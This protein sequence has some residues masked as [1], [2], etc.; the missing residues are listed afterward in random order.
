VLRIIA[1]VGE[2]NMC[3]FITYVLVSIKYVFM[4]LACVGEYKICLGEHSIRVCEYNKCW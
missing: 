3:W 2:H 4:I 1:C